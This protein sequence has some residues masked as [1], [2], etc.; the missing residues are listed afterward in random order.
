MVRVLLFFRATIEVQKMNVRCVITGRD[1][2]G[3]SVLARDQSVPPKGALGFEFHRLWG[4]DEQ[5]VLPGDGR[6]DVPRM[7]FPTGAGYRFGYF[8][9]PSHSDSISPQQFM[10]ALPQLQENVPGLVDVLEGTTGMHT[11]QTVDFDVVVS[12]EVWL[13]VDGGKEV[14]LK[15]GDCVVQNGTRH[16]WHNRS[17]QPCTL[18]VTLLAARR[19]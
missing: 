11:T 6:A 8:T 17:G 2:S 12:G 16:A 7:Y 9:I 4:S 18:A 10:T 5:A 13:E 3:T 14:L 19:K 1:E 15:A